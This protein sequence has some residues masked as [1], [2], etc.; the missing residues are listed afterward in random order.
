MLLFAWVLCPG[1]SEAPDFEVVCSVPMETNIS[2]AGTR[3][4]AAVWLEMVNG[5]RSSLDIAEFYLSGKKG[6]RWSR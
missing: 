5:A 6:K 4:A 3:D 1:S 2:R